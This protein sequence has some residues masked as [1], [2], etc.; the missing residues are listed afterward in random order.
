MELKYSSFA[1][2][3]FPILTGKEA[4]SWDNY[5]ITKENIDSTLLMAGDLIQ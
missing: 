5:S 3:T 1:K 4:A 2:K